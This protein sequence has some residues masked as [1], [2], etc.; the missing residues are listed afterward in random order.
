MGISLLLFLGS[1]RKVDIAT[2]PWHSFL[3]SPTLPPDDF[4]LSPPESHNKEL[5]V[6]RGDKQLKSKKLKEVSHVETDVGYRGWES[7]TEKVD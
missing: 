5:E 4:P 2:Q 3:L 7:F 6:G 1:G